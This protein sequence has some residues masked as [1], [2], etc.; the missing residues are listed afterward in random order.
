MSDGPRRL[1]I[2]EGKISG[3]LSIILAQFPKGYLRQLVYPFRND[4]E[5][6]E[7]ADPSAR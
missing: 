5:E 6:A 7:V 4:P 3:Y 2:G 1:R